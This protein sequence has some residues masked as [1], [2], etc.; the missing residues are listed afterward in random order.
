MKPF[1]YF[2][3]IQYKTFLSLYFFHK[4]AIRKKSKTFQNYVKYLGLEREKLIGHKAKIHH[5]N[6][7][8]VNGQKS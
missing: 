6:F 1:N 7:S 2:F 8:F 4:K 5:L 3:L